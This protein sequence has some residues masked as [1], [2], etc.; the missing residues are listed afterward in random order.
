MESRHVGSQRLILSSPLYLLEA[1]AHFLQT[2]RQFFGDSSSSYVSFDPAKELGVQ[3][4]R[5]LLA[6]DGWWVN[7]CSHWICIRHWRTVVNTSGAELISDY[8]CPSCSR[9]KALI[10]L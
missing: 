6:S 7:I 9:K 8:G 4:T 3:D 2:A 10:W 1:T 5:W